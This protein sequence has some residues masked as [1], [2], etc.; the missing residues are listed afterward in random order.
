MRKPLIAGNFKMHKNINE[1]VTHARGLISEVNSCSDRTVLICPPFTSLSEVHKIIKESSIRLGAQNMHF[2]DKG[3]FTG[4]LSAEMLLDVGCEYVI[5]GHSERRHIFNETCNFINLKVKKAIKSG[6]KPIL[7]VGELLEERETGIAE[8]IVKNQLEN[9]LK[10]LTESEVKNVVIAYEP[11]WA[12]GTGKT[13]T[14]ND[15]QTMHIFIRKTL[16]ILYNLNIAQ[17]I[18]IQY[19]GSVKPD[20]INSLMS[21]PDIDGVL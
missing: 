8:T 19:G 11:V 13:A 3:A 1:T 16:E 18:I 20:N 7:C 14:P 12:I 4:E 5:L 21:M 2:E 15:A 6:L 10:D 9:G 17:N